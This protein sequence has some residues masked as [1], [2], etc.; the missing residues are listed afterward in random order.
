MYTK[1]DFNFM[2][3]DFCLVGAGTFVYSLEI[4][5]GRMSTVMG[6]P[7]RYL[8]DCVM[9]EHPNLKFDR[10]IMIGD[11][12]V[13]KDNILKIESLKFYLLIHPINGH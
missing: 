12:W 10:C 8:L 13:N 5:T 9:E 6:K 2:L 3:F 1:A 11:K 7:E 4:V